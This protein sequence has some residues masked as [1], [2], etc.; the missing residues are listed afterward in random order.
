MPVSRKI[1][2][3]LREMGGVEAGSRLRWQAQRFFEAVSGNDICWLNEYWTRAVQTD[4]FKEREDHSNLLA[5]GLIGEAGSIAAEAKKMDRDGAAYPAYLSKLA[6]ECG[7]FLWYLVRYSDV[8]GAERPKESDIFDQGEADTK[9]LEL[10]LELCAIVARLKAMTGDASDAQLLLSI[11]RTFGRIVP[12]TGLDMREI[13][14][15]NLAKIESRWPKETIFHPLFDEEFPPEE[16]IPRKLTIDF[17]ETVTGD[18]KAVVLRYQGIGIGDRIT[19]NIADPDGYRF[20]DIFHIANAVYLGWSPVLRSLLRCKRKS[21]PRVDR[22][23]DGARA[24][25]IEEAVSATVFRRAKEMNYFRGAGHVDYDL[26]KLIQ[27]TVSGY[28]VDRVPLWQWERTI[29]EGYRL[30][31]SLLADGGGRISWDLIE[32]GISWS[33]L[34]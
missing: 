12:S 28:E 9:L 27:E 15:R 19:D 23:Q 34:K 8:V 21:L 16:Q 17:V 20:H 4:Q 1:C 5:A 31:D 30:F 25:I 32:R 26:L 14:K 3:T 18:T 13:G 29:L 22:N 11:W 33:S 10:S 7:D 24:A 6:E 2:G